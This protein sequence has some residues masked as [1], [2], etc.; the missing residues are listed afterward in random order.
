MT[1]EEFKKLDCG[2]IIVHSSEPLIAYI[3]M[4]NFGGRVT[5][6]RTADATNPTEWILKA[7][8]KYES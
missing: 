3:V 5:A 1:P 7:K 6:V 2:D 4:F 8:A